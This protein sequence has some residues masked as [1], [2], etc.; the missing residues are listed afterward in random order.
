[1]RDRLMSLPARVLLPACWLAWT[2]IFF[3]VGL[4]SGDGVLRAL[5]TA[6]IVAIGP[7]VPMG[8]VIRNRWR[9]E[10]RALGDVTPTDRS[11]AIRAARTGPIPT[12]P[13]V[14]TAA[15][16][17]AQGDLKRLLRWRPW[18][19]VILA[20][21]VVSEI[22]LAFTSSP[23]SLL[24]LVFLVPSFGYQL[25]VFPKRLQAR[26]ALLSAAQ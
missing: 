17:L 2:A 22:G 16:E 9:V 24:V 18:M 14:R 10:Q 21:L 5:V 4:I 8:L 15:L 11:T 19:T 7:G 20:L 13:E 12:D 6:A 23:W 25:F 26:I 1:M 3:V